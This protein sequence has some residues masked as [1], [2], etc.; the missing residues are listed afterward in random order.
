[1]NSVLTIEIRLNALSMEILLFIALLDSSIQFGSELFLF[2]FR[3]S[4][5]SPGYFWLIIA[6]RGNVFWYISKLCLSLKCWNCA[7][8]WEEVFRSIEIENNKCGASK[9]SHSRWGQKINC[10]KKANNIRLVRI[11]LCGGR[12]F[13][14]SD[15]IRSQIQTTNSC[16]SSNCFRAVLSNS[17]FS[18]AYEQES[19][20]SGIPVQNNLHISCYC[21]SNFAVFFGTVCH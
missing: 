5:L 12:D 15:S 9:K 10:K 1:M 7:S 14:Q 19:G 18:F 16:T 4:F 17:F 21:I 11:E 2:S 20:R 13:A 3:S 6:T 8:A